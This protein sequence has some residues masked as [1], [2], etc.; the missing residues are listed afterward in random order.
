MAMSRVKIFRRLTV[1]G[2]VWLALTLGWST[3]AGMDF[4][5]APDGYDSWSGTMARSGSK[6]GDGPLASLTGARDAIR[7]ARAESRLA[8]SEMARVV[9]ADGYYRMTEPLELGEA[10]GNVSYE[11]AAGARPVFSGGKLI[12][13]KLVTAGEV[14]RDRLGEDIPVSK[15]QRGAD[16]V[17]WIKVPEVAAGKWYF[18]QLWVNGRRATRART[19]NEF[20]FHLRDVAEEKIAGTADRDRRGRRTALLRDADFAALDGLADD[21]LR[22]VNLVVYHNWDVT[23]RFVTVDRQRHAV[24]TEGEMMWPWSPWKKDTPFILE[25]ARQFLDAPGEWFL[26]RDGTLSYL[27][28]P[29]EDMVS[30]EVVAP[31]AGKFIAIGGDP[32]A[33]RFA[34][35]ITFKGLTFEHAQWL[36]PPQGFEPAQAAAPIGAVIEFNG[37]R[38][39]TVSDCVVRHIG[40]YAVWARRACREVT[41]SECLLEDL[42]A[43]GVRIGETE[44]PEDWMLTG[45]VVV[46]NNIIRGGGHI[47]PC[48]V[49][50]WIG[51]SPDNKITHNE[52]ADWYYTGISVGWRWGYA[53]SRCQR[54]EVAFNRVHHLGKGLLSDMGGIYTL[55]PQPGTTVHD[56]VFF[57]IHSYA[58]G[59]WGIYP[60]EG[61]AGIVFENNLVYD[62]KSGGFHQHYGRENVLRNNIFAAARE[63]QLQFTRSENHLSFTFEKNI[64]W[65]DNASPLLAG[66]WGNGR[67]IMRDNCYWNAG[68]QPVKFINKPFAEWQAL[69]LRALNPAPADGQQPPWVGQGRD[70]G[71]VIADPLFVDAAAR[72]FRLRPDSPALKLGFKPFDYTRAG[73]YGA[74]AWRAKALSVTYPPV[75]LPPGKKF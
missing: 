11:A 14:Y 69:P 4:F 73:V 30:A 6:D 26:A 35:H 34:E 22:D 39:V 7:Q 2:G 64:V 32:T 59:G 67:E 60:D 49:G 57:D 66:D 37:A 28:L 12:G 40:T 61:S 75:P 72:D 56:N 31:V 8:R 53:A 70:S 9:V 1:S 52:I 16:G 71:S 68:G 3:A 23:R 50:V 43:G 15:W 62:T 44:A 47:F 48:A 65:W 17:W 5:I 46:D 45:G 33:G 55:G 29:D 25:N 19:P 41:V 27:P 58:Y 10:D 20:W 36:T 63:Q 74:A 42:G 18:E 24:I 21:E 13:N 38:G 54:N 51:A